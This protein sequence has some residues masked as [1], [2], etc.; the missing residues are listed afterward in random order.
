MQRGF[1]TLLLAAALVAL[2][3][4]ADDAVAQR[5][6]TAM[7]S[8]LAQ[9]LY[10]GVDVAVHVATV[11]GRTLYERDPDT[12]FIPASA[13]KIF[14]SAAALAL[15]G[16][17][18]R[19]ET[20]ILADG[21]VTDGTLE[22]ALYLV[23]RGDPSLQAADLEAAARKLHA[24]GIRSIRDGI[25]YDVSYLDVEKPRYPPNARH[26]YSPPG[27]LTVGYNW[28]VLGLDDGPPPRL[29]TIP[30]TSYARLSYD[31]RV[32]ASDR[33]GRPEMT[34][35]EESWG[36]AYSIRGTVT[37]WDKRYQ[38]LRLGVSRPG[39]Y[40]AT[41][42]KEAL[43]R[44]EVRI[45]GT[46]REGRA[47]A[48]ATTLLTI[49]TAPLVEA[50]RI[51]NRESNNV[52]AELVTKD[53]G[54]AFRGPPGTREKGLDVLRDFLTDK[55][56]LVPGSFK[57]N[58]ASGLSTANGF[59]A[60]QLTRSLNVFHREIGMV[61]VETLAP[62]G[63]HPHAAAVTPPAGLS[64][65]VKSGTLPETGVNTLVGYIVVDATG[66]VYSFALLTRRRGQGKP[67]YSGTYT[68]PLVRA[69]LDATLPR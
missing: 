34:Y 51:L 5:L 65:W 33:P 26:L 15:L 37:R 21:G 60:A 67:A 18:Y 8:C 25:V 46:F 56:G 22:G 69:L 20:P 45:D 23:G 13:A 17:E 42:L 28:I 66:D 29:W 48:S 57:L 62:Q 30:E 58:D 36:D 44:N 39:L 10:T 12:L 41:L 11:D 14:S 53:L 43:E 49:R 4:Q 61:F 2:P 59:S 63:H 47:P 40:A 54:A 19:F 7:A 27:A 16:P 68:N 38:Y 24:Q 1:R 6:R 64:A 50:V 32:E 55:V 35:R 31:I 52:V 3:A 9:P